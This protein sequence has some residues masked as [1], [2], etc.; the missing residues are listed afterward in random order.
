MD[1]SGKAFNAALPLSS[2]RC[3]NSLARTRLAR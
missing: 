3:P 1:F 2:H